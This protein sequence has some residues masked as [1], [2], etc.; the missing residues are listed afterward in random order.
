MG[1]PAA[2]GTEEVDTISH[3]ADRDFDL[4]G[5]GFGIGALEGAA[6]EDDDVE[7]ILCSLG[8]DDLIRDAVGLN[9]A[10]LRE[11]QSVTLGLLVCVEAGV[12]RG[13]ERRAEVKQ[14]ETA[15]G[16]AFGRDCDAAEISDD[17]A[18]AFGS[19]GL[20]AFGHE[21]VRATLAAD[22]ISDLE[23]GRQTSRKL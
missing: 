15:D 8:V 16:L 2:D 14:T 11:G 10:K 12:R 21:R 20:E 7:A 13:G 1:T 9:L 4:L 3:G 23:L 6:L 18:Q 22:N 17:I 5:Q 19:K